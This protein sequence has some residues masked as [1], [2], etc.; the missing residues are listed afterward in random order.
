MKQINKNELELI[1]Q[2]S[3]GRF[4]K[5]SSTL[6]KPLIFINGQLDPKIQYL[7]NCLG[8]KTLSKKFYYDETYHT[9]YVW[10]YDYDITNKDT[11]NMTFSYSIYKAMKEYGLKNVDILGFSNGGTIAL[12]CSQFS[13]VSKVLAVH[14]S[15]QG[16]FLVYSKDLLDSLEN[17]SLFTQ[18]LLNTLDKSLTKDFGYMQENGELLKDFIHLVDREKIFITH[19]NIVDSQNKGI[20]FNFGKYLAMLGYE[21]Y[22]VGSDGVVVIDENYLI[23]HKIPYLLD[24]NAAHFNMNEKRIAED[25]KLILGKK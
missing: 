20:H 2:D 21:V 16:S 9:P 5:A 6:E 7:L 25:Y 12:Y 11:T 17:P 3:F 1:Y 13:N 23:K 15:I 14:P 19:G 18:V 8:I 24:N 10:V 22:N 4:Y